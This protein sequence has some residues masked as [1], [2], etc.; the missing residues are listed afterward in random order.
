MHRNGQLV[1]LKLPCMRLQRRGPAEIDATM[2]QDSTIGLRHALTCLGMLTA[3]A[4]PAQ[5]QEA[6]DLPGMEVV[7]MHHGMSM[8]ELNDTWQAHAEEAVLV[9]QGASLVTHLK[10]GI[11][12]LTVTPL[13]EVQWQLDLLARPSI[14][15]E[16]VVAIPTDQGRWVVVLPQAKIDAWT[17]RYVINAK[18]LLK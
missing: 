16:A 1:I 8:S 17:D 10:D 4:M 11:D 2:K 12:V 14:V 7:L 18:A 9:T 13:N 6:L 5:G 15:G 3:L